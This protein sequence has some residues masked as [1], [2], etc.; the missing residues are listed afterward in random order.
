VRVDR[1]ATTVLT[2]DSLT[3]PRGVTALVG[4]NGSGKS[5]LLH[6][7]AG[8]LEPTR[9]TV[10]VGGR[11][12]DQV[13]RDTAYV[14]QT[15]HASEHLLITAHE[16]VSL[17]R[18]ATLGPFRRAGRR[19]REAVAVA[20]DRLDVGDLGR[21]HLAEMSGGQRQRVFVAQG[22]AQDAAVLLLDEPMAGLDMVSS[23][24]IR[25]VI[26][27]E[28]AAGRF[29]LVATHDLDDARQADHV[30]LLNG[31]VVAQGP[32]DVALSAERL[33]E[34]YGSRVL[35]LGDR[36]VAVDDGVHHDDVEHH[37]HDHG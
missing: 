37:H 16:V 30:V 19:D 26:D 34:A 33:R 18:A 35:D 6:L 14:L 9:G 4:P 27:D 28:R 5:T 29:V 3:I 20:M 11:R 8:L 15:Q 32:P 1:G 2:V 25:A 17:A 36:T 23:Q 21:R 24:R 10:T 31:R 7:V 13:R 22:L 12:P